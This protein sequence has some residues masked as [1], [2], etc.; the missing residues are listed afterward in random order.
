MNSS[1]LVG[2]EKQV[3]RPFVLLDSMEVEFLGT[4]FYLFIGFPSVFV[5]EKY[6]S[7]WWLLG[8]CQIV[9]TSNSIFFF[10]SS[11]LSDYV[12]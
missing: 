9:R 3:V 6:Q 11:N 1:Q 12:A 2:G 10:P 7:S 4:V 5:K 8:S